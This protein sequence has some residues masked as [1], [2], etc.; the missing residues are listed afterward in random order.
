M[1]SFLKI[2]GF[3]IIGLGISAAVKA[4]AETTGH[5]PLY[6]IDGS[7][8]YFVP[9]TETTARLLVYQESPDSWAYLEVA[10][11]YPETFT[12][13]IEALKLAFPNKSVSWIAGKAIGSPTVR[14]NSLG[15]KGEGKWIPRAAGPSLSY[16]FTLTKLQTEKL[17]ASNDPGIQILGTIEA[18]VTSD[19]ILES[20]SLGSE[21]C[22]ALVHEGESLSESLLRYPSVVESVNRKPVRYKSTRDALKKSVLHD[23]IV[24]SETSPITSF[25]EFLNKKI[26][27]PIPKI[28]PR[29]ETRERRMSREEGNF[30]TYPPKRLEVSGL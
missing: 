12:P 6:W 14:V 1:N 21:I 29:G 28:N 26:T 8:L 16:M 19:Q 23:C 24:F 2:L 15:I 22:E 5:L 9:M 13:Q 17:L 11:D 25:S 4:H 10:A 18:Q 7:N 20:V 3:L 30:I 27:L